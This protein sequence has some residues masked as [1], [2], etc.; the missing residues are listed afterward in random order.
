MNE[1]RAKILISNLLCEIVDHVWEQGGEQY[2][3][4]LIQEVGFTK[5]EI[6]ELKSEGF[7]HSPSDY[8]RE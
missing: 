4:W 1:I 2:D 3:A 6:N 5:E 8:E 7:F